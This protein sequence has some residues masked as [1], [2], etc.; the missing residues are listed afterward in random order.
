MGKTGDLF[1]TSCIKYP[2]IFEIFHA[3]WCISECQG[4]HLLL[5]SSFTSAE[6][7]AYRG[8]PDISPI[9]RNHL[10]SPPLLA[11][12]LSGMFAAVLTGESAT[13][14][15][16][17][18]FQGKT[19]RIRAFPIAR[20]R[21]ENDPII[22]GESPAWTIPEC[23]EGQFAKCSECLCKTPQCGL[24]RHD[25]ASMS[26]FPLGSRAKILNSMLGKLQ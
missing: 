6:P 16:Y 20:L 22:V 19:N 1:A 9:V 26:R 23:G 17:G 18:R 10:P 8:I 15:G 14:T 3:P 13:N 11:E 4:T 2:R 24:N 21:P 5:L 7:D 25:G 12:V